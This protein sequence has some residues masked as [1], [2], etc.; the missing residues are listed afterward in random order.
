MGELTGWGL[1]MEQTLGLGQE[2]IMVCEELISGTPMFYIRNISGNLFSLPRVDKAGTVTA[3]L[4]NAG[5]K[6]SMLPG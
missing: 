3:F 2:G 5:L 6:G 4:I 1:A